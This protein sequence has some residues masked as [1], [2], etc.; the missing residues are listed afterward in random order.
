MNRLVKCGLALAV[1]VAPVAAQ[2]DDQDIMNYRKQVMKTMGEQSAAMNMTL[3]GKAPAD[4]FV[5]HVKTLHLAATQA[6]K[7]FEPKV[8]GDGSTGSAKAEVWANW[9]DFSKRMDEQ[10][11]KLAALEKAA[12]EGGAAKA[13]PM[14][15]TSLDCRGCHETYRV[16]KK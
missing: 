10:V 8:V 2:A 14:I 1:L 3:Q 6:K 5:S 13:G 15:Q 9:A 16:P 4:Q 7:A 12:V 11:A